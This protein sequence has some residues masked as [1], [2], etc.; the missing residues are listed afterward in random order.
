MVKKHKNIL[1]NTRN[2]VIIRPSK[3]TRENKKKKII[4]FIA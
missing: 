3:T 2:D 4:Q 1:T